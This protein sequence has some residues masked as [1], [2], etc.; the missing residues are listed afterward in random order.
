MTNVSLV[1]RLGGDPEVRFTQG[2]HAVCSFSLAVQ[3]RKQENGQWVDGDT[4]W[5]RVSAWRRLGENCAESLSKGDL[6][7][8]QGRL[9]IRQYDKKDGSGKATSVD[10]TAE[11]VGPSLMFA[12]AKPVSAE[13]QPQGSAT[14]MQSGASEDIPF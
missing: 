7:L 9:A 1:G 3:E 13:Y 12:T 10:V 2:G 5:Y 8:V 11:H 4:S 6:V 14:P